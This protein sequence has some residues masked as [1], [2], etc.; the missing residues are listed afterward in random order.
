MVAGLAPLSNSLA[1]VM[2][3]QRLAVSLALVFSA[4]VA[5]CDDPTGLTS[6]PSTRVTVGDTVGATIESGG[7]PHVFTFEADQGDTIAVFLHATAGAVHLVVLGPDASTLATLGDTGRQ[8]ALEER[9]AGPFLTTVSGTH[10][11]RV[12]A[13]GSA[14]ATF[15]LRIVAT[16]R[17][18]ERR[19]AALVLGDTLRG[20][21]LETPLDVDEFAFQG[22]QGDEL[23]A[24]V[25]AL[26]PHPRAPILMQIFLA[27]ND[28]RFGGLASATSDTIAADLEAKPTGRFTL[29]QTGEY[30]VRVQI[31]DSFFGGGGGYVAGYPRG[32]EL[33]VRRIVRAPERSLGPLVPGDT[34]AAEAIDY[35]GDLDEF[36]I[37]APA[38]REYNL[39]LER[40]GPGPGG[41]TV[42]VLGATEPW[43]EPVATATP[44]APLRATATGRFRIPAGAT[45]RVHVA[46]DAHERA[47]RGPYRIFLYPVSY[48]PETAS[49]SLT[50]GDSITGEAIELA[51]DVDEFTLTVPDTSLANFVMWRDGRETSD[52]MSL[53]VID[54]GTGALVR[55]TETW[56]AGSEGV[57]GSATGT[58]SLPA[59]TYRLRVSGGD[60]RGFGYRG[61]YRVHAL[62]INPAPESGPSAI[63]FGDTVVDAV[64]PLGDIDTFTFSGRLMQHVGVRI[65]SVDGEPL[66]NLFALVRNARTR[67]FL[68][69][70]WYDATRTPRYDLPEDGEYT[71]EYLASNGGRLLREH[72]PY[73]LI[74][75]T[76][77]TAPEHHGTTVTPGDSIVD[78]SLDF[79]GDIDYYV[80]TGAP[81][82]ELTVMFIGA[83]SLTELDLFDLDTRVRVDGTPSAGFLQNTGRFNLPPSGRLGLRVYGSSSQFSGVTG[84]YRIAV[85][86]ID[87]SPEHVGA[88]IDVDSIID[89][90]AVDPDTDIDEFTF[91]APAGDRVDVYFQTP[92][93]VWGWE[94]LELELIDSATGTILGAVRSV[95]PTP[96]L[97]D[98]GTGPIVLPSTGNY[99][100]R[101]RGGLDWYGHGQYRFQVKRLP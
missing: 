60:T 26:A 100:I 41:L 24:Y 97:D 34:L 83:G 68:Q 96:R 44:G 75:D 28:P 50:L 52:H 37:N 70:Q 21:D 39:F 33:Q 3:R 101:V 5:A 61:A 40:S 94:G 8:G 66:T 77:S 36:T 14:G 65:E 18:P 47:Y 91:S 16:A 10:T 87:R 90:E 49:A 22:Q 67:Q 11:V 58:F 31:G 55:S 85:L 48:A 4:F 73:R 54:L 1:S 98:Q 62:A 79:V 12:A 38:D 35:V 84:P 63:A 27:G 7:D 69:M 23:I 46:G 51:G 86:R 89:G 64:E 20:E 32:Y 15:R 95:G 78:E 57:T 92:Q 42:R 76:L 17:G 29:P 56:H 88:Q 43:G 82:E 6:N 99:M 45:V 80:L 81:G 25:R 30:R 59:G 19:P 74:F 9:A 2:T 53:Y 72:G 93:G 71:I 13:V